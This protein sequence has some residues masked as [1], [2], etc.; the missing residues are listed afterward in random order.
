VGYKT[1]TYQYIE[2]VGEVFRV[3]EEFSFADAREALN[4]SAPL[5]LSG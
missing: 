4:E 3:R 5:S 2:F 1:D